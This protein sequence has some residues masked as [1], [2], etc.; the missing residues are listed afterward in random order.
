MPQM[1]E[2]GSK[3]KTVSAQHKKL[4]QVAKKKSA[5]KSATR[6]AYA[7]QYSAIIVDA[8]T[9]RVLHD[10]DADGIRYPASLTKMMTL[11]LTFEALEQD[12]LSF[13]QMLPVSAKA[14]KQPQ[15]NIALKPGDRISVR[16]AV[17]SLVVRSANDSAM[18][19]AEAVGKSEFNFGLM[20]TSKARAL[21]MKNTVFRN[22][23]GLPDSKQHTT[24]R[25]MAMLGLALQRD[26]P[27]YYP[28]F[29]TEDFSFRGRTYHTHN[30]VM[31]R[32]DGVDG[33][34]TG[35]INASGFNLVTSAKRNRHR[36]VAVVMGGR[37][38][39]ARDNQMIALLDRTFL[40]LAQ[41]R[42]DTATASYAAPAAPVA[43]GY[44]PN[45]VGQGSSDPEPSA[46][47][48]AAHMSQ[49]N[50]AAGNWGI[51]VGTYSGVNQAVKAASDARML[52]VQELAKAKLDISDKNT[53]ALGVHR[54][55]LTA[56]SEQDAKTACRKLSARN[57]ACFAY[58][59]SAGQNS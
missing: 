24:A 21:G 10:D 5:S 28:Y 26:F 40:Q 43:S 23:N 16:D 29:K 51:Q 42:T 11:Y 22:P 17:L 32:Y 25:D 39:V 58:P 55:R 50:P 1:A 54:A 30:H 49:E 35:Y 57:T 41:G 48:P 6:R 53:P 45:D 59:L 37:T 19:L 27:G 38:A 20:M 12:R 46:P 15:T 2:A 34:K 44:S 4:K 8:D 14:A 13:N 7:P 52:A 9:G 47:A 3:S 33:I 36:V 31:E 56:L 18:V